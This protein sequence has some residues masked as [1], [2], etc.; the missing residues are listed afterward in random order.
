MEFDPHTF[1]CF[2]FATIP[3]SIFREF[4]KIFCYF[5]PIRYLYIIICILYN[6]FDMD[7]FFPYACVIIV[8]VRFLGKAG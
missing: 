2:V 4:P 8:A 5:Q 6:F 3:H 1:I 7:C